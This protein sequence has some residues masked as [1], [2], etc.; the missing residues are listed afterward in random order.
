[1]RKMSISSCE[2][3]R[4]IVLFP[5][6]G[7]DV[8]LLWPSWLA[9]GNKGWNTRLRPAAIWLPVSV[10]LL[11]GP[12]HFGRFKVIGTVRQSAELVFCS[13]AGLVSRG[14]DGRRREG[15]RGMNGWMDG[16]MQSGVRGS[17]VLEDQAPLNMHC[18][19]DALLPPDECVT[20]LVPIAVSRRQL[21]GEGD[22]FRYVGIAERGKCKGF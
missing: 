19:Q 21:C 6:E 14:M 18:G 15:V 1:M 16:W 7:I 8:S 13:A 20:L 12:A 5:G 11:V 17:G 10:E 2:K 22:Q 4:A 3:D 9:R